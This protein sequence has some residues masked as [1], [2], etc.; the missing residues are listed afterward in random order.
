MKKLIRY[1][2][3]VVGTTASHY[4][5]ADG[6]TGAGGGFGSLIVI[7]AIGWICSSVYI[8]IVLKNVTG[9]KSIYSRVLSY[10]G[11]QFW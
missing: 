11:F 5:F 4:T 6:G 3:L 9:K 1:L 2:L 10:P 8:G 7:T